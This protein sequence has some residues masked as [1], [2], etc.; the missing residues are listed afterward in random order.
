VF[1]AFV[2]VG[3]MGHVVFDWEWRDEDPDEPGIPLGSQR[4]FA[5]RVYP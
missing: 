1:L 3:M 4:D 2:E 5:E